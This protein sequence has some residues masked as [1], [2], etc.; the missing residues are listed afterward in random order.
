M[1]IPHSVSRNPFISLVDLLFVTA[2][3]SFLVGCATVRMT[4][5]DGMT[6]ILETKGCTYAVLKEDALWTV[7]PEQKLFP[8]RGSYALRVDPKTNRVAARVHIPEHILT[9]F[10]VGEGALWVAAGDYAPEISKIDPDTGRVVATVRVGPLSIFGSPVHLAVGAGA[11]WAVR[12]GDLFRMDPK[13]NEVTSIPI[14]RYVLDVTII[15]NTVW[16]HLLDQ[17]AISRI[18]ARTG[19]LAAT[20]IASP[21][22]L[23]ITSRDF[24]GSFAAAER[25]SWSRWMAAGAEGMWVLLHFGKSLPQHV[26]R[27]DLQLNQIVAS[28][29]GQF[30]AIITDIAASEAAIWVAAFNKGWFSVTTHYSIIELDP[31]TTLVKQKIPYAS[32]SSIYSAMPTL[33]VG[34]GTM[35]ICLPDSGLYRAPLDSGKR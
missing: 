3:G 19:Q 28:N 23:D 6:P 4:M 16:V 18:D 20:P 13:S 15:E 27:V 11:V 21:D 9:S 8:P 7:V 2:I 10:D 24:F 32:V 25:P 35:W 33:A 31:K 29:Q 1:A 34:A 14:A 30:E 22:H 12:G 26:G 17:S 5:P